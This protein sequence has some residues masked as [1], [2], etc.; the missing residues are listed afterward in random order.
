MPGFTGAAPCHQESGLVKGVA[1]HWYL[2]MWVGPKQPREDARKE[3]GPYLVELPGTEGVAADRDKGGVQPGA[4]EQ[5]LGGGS[6]EEHLKQH[7]SRSVATDC[8]RFKGQ[9]EGRAA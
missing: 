7:R 8:P 5:P 6:A 3:L 2:S 1:L 4:E 9:C